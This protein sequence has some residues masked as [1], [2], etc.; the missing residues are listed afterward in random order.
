MDEN[1]KTSKHAYFSYFRVPGNMKKYRLHISI[2]SYLHHDAVRPPSPTIA[3]WF[4]PYVGP[5]KKEASNNI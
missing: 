2:F 5:R 4:K 3:I 1:M